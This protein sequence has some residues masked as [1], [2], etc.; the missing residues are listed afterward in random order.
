MKDIDRATG[1]VDIDHALTQL[2]NAMKKLSEN[3]LASDVE[4]IE[5]IIPKGAPLK[6]ENE[7]AKE[8]YLVD[9]LTG[10]RIKLE[11][12]RNLVMVIQ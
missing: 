4:R 9:A 11:G 8:G 7:S 3:G 1:K 2:E 12:F 10:K 5:F 6:N